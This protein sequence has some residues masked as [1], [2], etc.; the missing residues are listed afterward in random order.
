M[1]HSRNVSVR[2]IF[3]LFVWTPMA[4]GL[5]LGRAFGDRMVL[6]MQAAVAVFGVAKPGERVSVELGEV[7]RFAYASPDGEW[8]VMLPPMPPSTEGMALRVESGA[9]TRVLQDVL[10]GEVWLCAGQSNMDFPLSRAVGGREEAK[11]AGDFP[12]IRLRNQSGV[13]TSGR[14]Y[15]AAERERLEPERFFQGEWRV[16]SEESAAAFSAVGWWAGKEIHRKKRVPVGLIDVSVGGSGTEAWLPRE[17][18]EA[19]EDYAELLGGDWVESEKMS[20]WARGRAKSNLGG[21]EGRHPFQPGFLFDAGVRAWRGFPLSG[22]LWY[23]GE[24]NAEIHDDAWNER[25]ITDLVLGWRRVLEQPELPFFMVQLPRIGG[26]DPLRK[27]WPQYR[28]VQAR[29]AAKLEGVEVIVT[30]DLGWDSPD[31]HPP[32]KRPVGERLGRAVVEAR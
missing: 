4:H 5:E 30:K 6:P 13:H 32:D 19:R 16:A 11:G 18:L 26:D 29:A 2:L 28:E 7:E 22:V 1:G 25:L 21:S 10:V 14:G 23:Q 8:R 12:A 24:T 15:S 20:A 31:V 9:E 27:W 17:V 3:A